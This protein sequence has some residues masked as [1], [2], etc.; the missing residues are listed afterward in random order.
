MQL[1]YKGPRAELAIADIEATAQPVEAAETGSVSREQGSRRGKQSRGE[2]GR[3]WCEP[4]SVE[5]TYF[6]ACGIER[7]F[8]FC[9]I[10]WGW[11]LTVEAVGPFECPARAV[12]SSISETQ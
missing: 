4:V 7:A 8:I 6:R 1:R 10:S 5:F 3:I 11:I 9:W 2:Q 12:A